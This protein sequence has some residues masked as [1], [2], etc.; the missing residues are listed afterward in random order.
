MPILLVPVILAERP[1]WYKWCEYIVLHCTTTELLLHTCRPK[2]WDPNQ[3]VC[4]L[5]T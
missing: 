4:A 1:L 2:P 3:W 5:L